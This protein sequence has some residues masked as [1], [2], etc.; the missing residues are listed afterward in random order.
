M[1]P[2]NSSLKFERTHGV[3]V[4]VIPTRYGTVEIVADG[5][6]SAPDEKQMLALDPFFARASE[7]TEATKKKLR[8]SFLYR[9]IR[10]APNQHGRVGLQFRN[11]LTGSQPLLFIDE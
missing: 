1:T 10:V 11:R 5:T 7:I 6:D 2:V 3:W 4:A 9:L 8:F